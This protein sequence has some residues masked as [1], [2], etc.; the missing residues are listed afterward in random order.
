[1]GLCLEH[2]EW[3]LGAGLDAV[4]FATVYRAGAASRGSGGE[5]LVAAGGV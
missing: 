4:L 1:M 2:G 5:E 3:E